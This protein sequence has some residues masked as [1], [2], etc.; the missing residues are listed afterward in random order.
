[1][2]KKNKQDNTAAE[3]LLRPEALSDSETL[4]GMYENWFLDYASYVILERAVPKLEDGLKPVQRRILHA[5]KQMD[6]GRFHKVANVI[7]QTMQYHPHGDA[8]IEDALVALGQKNLLVDRQGNWGDPRTGDKAAAARYIESRLTKFALEVAFNAETTEWQASYDGRKK[9]PMAL[10]MKFPLLLFQGVEG[11][12]VGLATKIMPHNFVELIKASIKILK[13]QKVT[14]VPDFPSGGSGDFENYNNGLK[15][16]KIR[17]RAT[18]EQL[19]KKT[20]IIK[21]VPYGTTTNSLIDSIVKANDKNKIKINKIIDNTAKDVAILVE[22]APTIS[23]EVT[24][25]ALYAFTDCEVSIS[26]NSCVIVDDKPIFMG[27][28]EILRLSTERTLDLLREELEI[29]LNAL[30]ER[31]H[32]SSLEKIFIENRIY[33]KIENC[34]TWEAVISTIDKGLKPFKKL[35]MRKVTEEDIVKLTEIKIKR[36]SKYDAFKADEAIGRLEESIAEVEHH[37]ENMTAYAIDY[38]KNLLKKYGKDKERKTAI[39]SFSNIQVKH[40]AIANR[41]LYVD[42]KSGFIGSGLKGTELVGECSDIDDII[43]FRKDG[44]MIVSRLADKTF[45]GKDIIHVA[46]WK[47]SDDRKVYNI[48]YSDPA[49]NKNYAKRFA[50]TA[51]TRD[52]EYD[53]TKG[54]KRSKLLYF[55]ANPNG[56]A[57]IVEVLL[58]SSCKAKIKQ[59]D[60]DFSTLAVKGRTSQGNIITRWPIRKV[61]LKEA[62]VSTLGGRELWLDTHSGRLNP[63][64]IGEYL[65]EFNTGDMIL[66]IYKDGSYKLTDFELT[67]RY[68]S[69]EVVEVLKFDPK[70]IVSCVYYHGE[71]KEYFVK[72]FKIENKKIGQKHFFVPET[73]GTKIFVAT[74]Q[75]N[76][77]VEFQETKGTGRS[78]TVEEAKVAV[79]KLIDVKGWKSLGNRLSRHKVSK[80]KVVEEIGAK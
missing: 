18:I 38:F 65:G 25:D 44:K 50:V 56:E 23:P 19:D 52:K 63:R 76:P 11:I 26:P 31:W 8:S 39:K 9:E 51:I 54:D 22:L 1:M 58:S 34:T 40:V 48:I 5:L 16:G 14:I 57:E 33:R 30:K 41:K 28:S 72:R 80:L 78:K 79:K 24:R 61:V 77:V 45:V 15:G 43:I 68:L 47:K 71:K 49:S 32:M 4:A 59:F 27:I 6:D 13:G 36:I 69:D 12:A 73:R 66:A 74:T 2:A 42:R 21:D 75:K 29:R 60:F 20:L 35:L 67:N 53:L 62:G 7:G 37:L 46:V 55:S 70:F 64:E 10:P 17:H 3:K